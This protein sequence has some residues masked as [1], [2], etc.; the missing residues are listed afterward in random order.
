MNQVFLVEAFK[1]NHLLLDT[2]DRELECCASFC[3]ASKTE[4][5]YVFKNRNKSC[6]SFASWAGA[7]NYDSTEGE[8]KRLCQ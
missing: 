2:S 1:G 3:R 4:R 6:L 5:F 8:L 7:W